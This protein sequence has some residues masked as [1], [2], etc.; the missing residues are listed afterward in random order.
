MNLCPT[1]G[2]ENQERAKFCSDCGAA[3]AAAAV[4][5]REERKVV[6][7]LFADLVGF[8]SRSERMDPEDVRALLSP[9]YTRLRTELERFGG[10]V[11][12][13]IGDA[14][15]ALF[16]APM[17]HED[18]PERAVRAALAIRDWVLEEQAD[19]QVRIAVNTG[20]ALVALGARPSQGE[21]M[22]SGDVV[23]T[24]A[25]LQTAAPVNG[26]LV[27]ETT[28]RATSQVINYRAAEPVTAK[29]KTEPV[30]VWE[31]LEAR[32]RLGG[33]L[34][35][36]RTPL[37]GRARE[38]D[39]LAV[40]LAGVRRD[41]S[42][43]LVT[44]AGV[45]GIGKSRLVAELFRHISDDPSELILWRQGRSLPYGNGVTF[46]A[47]AEMVKAQAGILETDSPEGA[48]EKLRL[49]VAAMIS[50]PSDA[51]WVEGHLRPLA[52][53]GGGGAEGGGDRQSEAFTA[54]RRFFEALAEQHPLVLVFDDLQWADDNLLDF[55][56][57]LIDWASGVPLLVVCIARPELFERRNGWGGGKRNATTA[58]LAPLTE[59]E[60]A[61]LISSLSERPVMSVETQEALLARAG[62]NPLY[63]EQYVRMIAE[64]ANAETLPLP[65]T[66]Q[67]I[68]AA[69]IDA[70]SGEE[71]SLLQNAAVM[72]KIFWLGAVT[73]LG[74]MDPHVAEL[75]LHTL[76]RKDFVQRVRG[77]SVA[78]QAEYA[79]L[80]VLVRDVAY[81]QI[82]RAQRAEKHRLAA[83]WIAAMGRT[84]DHA[85][86]LAHH[87]RSALELRRAAGQPVDS[88]FAE[89][90]MDS[91]REAG[92]R[93]FSLNAYPSAAGFY[94]S[95]LELASSGSVAHAQLLF[96][97]GRTRLS[98]A[99]YDPELLVAASGEL[100]GCGDQET[101]AEAE[102]VL[103]ELF[104]VRGEHDNAFEH[105]GRARE[106]VETRE[107]SRVKAFVTSSLSRF[108]MLASE[109]AEAIRLGRE[110]LGMAELLGL[111]ELRASTLNNIGV[112]RVQS[113]D[114]G[115]LR[116]L[117]ES[118]A[119]GE[120]ANAPTEVARAQ[121]NL[122][123]V[124]WDQG[125]LARSSALM[126][127]CSALTAR[128]GLAGFDRWI[129]GESVLPTYTLGR[130]GKALAGADEFLAEVEAG[131]PHYH[132]SLCYLIRAHIRLGR[133]D[134]PQA[135]GDVE[136]AVE[137]ARL[138][139]D[140]Q[141]LD[142]TLAAAAHLFHEIGMVQRASGLA[143]EALA[144]LR[145]RS[146]LGG[147][148]GWL[149][150]LAWT[151]SALGRGWELIDVLP[152]RDSRWAQAAAAFAAGNLR[153]AADICG[154]MGAVADEAH[155][156]LRLA[157]VLVEQSRR[158]E[159]D[160]QL[161]RA[162]AFYR[163]VG[164]TRYIRQAEAL[165][166]ASA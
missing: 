36:A 147:G 27:G 134:I 104:W 62:G 21:G 164:A 7:V 25:R 85:E 58:S 9:Y 29:G 133:D 78:E 153:D 73:R 28:Y 26:I 19:L 70:L 156:R 123:S 114:L 115:G 144:K 96:K 106:M 46:W 24:T 38:V 130:W 33:D 142:A 47:L 72:G 20:E 150:K 64:R 37:I 51:Q 137:L 129:R 102:A 41:R 148:T 98:E 110:A 119:V 146:G 126:D 22:A 84:E 92:D 95:A 160:T 32:S 90:A 158:A 67:G 82:P 31:A 135:L 69:R 97:L 17:A 89:R 13:F 63:A 52:G 34:A 143:D 4:S 111:D 49:A 109:D 42:P 131:S 15:M 50:D 118:I 132:A 80:H 139:K 128:F 81:A 113:G 1:C 3:L 108:L 140:P 122:A 74:E 101:A 149:H 60:T 55:V 40:A 23:N 162:L 117:D 107:I 18:D 79:F 2:H 12:K 120:R 76:Q 53:L 75:H 145:A 155:D 165:L 93:A 161:Q 99:N 59:D 121:I 61:E 91:I 141:N 5:A 103:G 88:S 154:A 54:W 116:D 138:A 71:K 43:H 65:E 16:G 30:P 8:T 86:M 157:E 100:L 136:R 45:P 57:Y 87:Y 124:L 14:V 166:A 66:V 77:S 152:K 35:A 48:A 68:I 125:E 159:A 11:E 44:I 94:Q 105:L 10:T 127:E 6:T 83:E 56:E 112:S 163:S 39:V 151:L